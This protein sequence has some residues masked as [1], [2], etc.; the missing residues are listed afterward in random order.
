M[1]GDDLATAYPR[2]ASAPIAYVVRHQYASDHH[3]TATLFQTGEIN[4][5]KFQGGSAIRTI[6]L[7]AAH[8]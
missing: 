5:Q 6:D 2:V 1:L 8:A 4:A 7:G 3:N